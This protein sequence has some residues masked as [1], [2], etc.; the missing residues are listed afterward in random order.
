MVVQ[1]KEL[2]SK[3]TRIGHKVLVAVNVVEKSKEVNGEVDQYFEFEQL[4]YDVSYSDD[5]L[6]N[7]AAKYEKST[8]AAIAKQYLVDTGWYVERLND[9]SSGKEI[10][11]EVVEKRAAA[12]AL[13]NELEG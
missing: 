8:A 9:P 2:P 4:E 13:I 3:I 11:V 6:L 10:P 12:R 1:S 5:V 7:M